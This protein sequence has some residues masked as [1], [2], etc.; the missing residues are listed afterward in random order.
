MFLSPI[1]FYHYVPD[2]E[3]NPLPIFL[4]GRHSSGLVSGRAF[5]VFS[6]LVI[7]YSVTGSDQNYSSRLSKD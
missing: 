7:T 2:F 4:V 5:G 3:D 1:I 6:D